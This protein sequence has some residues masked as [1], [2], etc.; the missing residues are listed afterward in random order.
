MMTYLLL[1]GCV[2]PHMQEFNL[3]LTSVRACLG[4]LSQERLFPGQLPVTSVLNDTVNEAE[5]GLIH[6]T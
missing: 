2:P 4:P 1:I 3:L 6:H 5:A